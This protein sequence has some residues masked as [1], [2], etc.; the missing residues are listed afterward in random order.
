MALDDDLI[1]R[2][3]AA[4]FR[5]PW[6]AKVLGAWNLHRQTLAHGAPIELFVLYSSMVAL[7]G[8]LGQAGYAAANAYLDA[9]ARRRRARGLPAT[10]VHWGSLAEA[11][12]VARNAAIARHLERTGL[13]GI[14]TADALAVLGRLL[15]ADRSGIGVARVDWPLWE[16]ALPAVARRP[17]FDQVVSQG[18]HGG[19]GGAGPSAAPRA[20]ALA[21]QAAPA[22]ER[23]GRAAEVLRQ[24]VAHVLRLPPSRLDPHQN[25]SQLGIDSLMAVE[26]QTLVADRTGVRFSPMDFMAGPTV[27]SMAARVVEAL[28]PEGQPAP[29]GP[30]MAAVPDVDQLSDAEV[31]DLLT[32]IISQ[33]T[34]S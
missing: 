34:S 29:G 13:S 19:D 28:A 18:S 15:A 21:L 14:A 27:L 22:G 4:R 11:G 1:D 7:L 32:R 25:L 12:F 16:Q 2:L 31:D 24:V 26:L 33:E 8:N 6:T 30:A 3:D 23:L 9:L 10:S 20:F 17:R 5:T